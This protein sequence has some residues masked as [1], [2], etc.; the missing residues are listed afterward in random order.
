[1]VYRSPS[2]WDEHPRLIVA[3]AATLLMQSLLIVGL[4]VQRSRMKQAETACFGYIGGVAKEY[5]CD[6]SRDTRERN[7]IKAE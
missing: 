2:L 6:C 4:L 7:A 1:V 3:T 5:R